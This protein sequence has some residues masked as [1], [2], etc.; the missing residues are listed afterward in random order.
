MD[1]AGACRAQGHKIIGD[2]TAHIV[3]YRGVQC[4]KYT[5]LNNAA[6]AKTF[7]IFCRGLLQSSLNSKLNLTG[8]T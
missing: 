4:L 3:Q 8:L 6:L 2:E 7:Q 5:A 1:G